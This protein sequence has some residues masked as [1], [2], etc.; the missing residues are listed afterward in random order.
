MIF[1]SETDGTPS[2]SRGGGPAG[3][4]V[5]PLPAGARGISGLGGFLPCF[6]GE[7]TCRSSTGRADPNDTVIREVEI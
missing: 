5:H 4:V 3:F 6:G 2:F 1:E 7:R